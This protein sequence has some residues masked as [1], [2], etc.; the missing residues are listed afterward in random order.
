MTVR[1]SEGG[2]DQGHVFGVLARH[3]V[4]FEI[5]YGGIDEIA[6]RTFGTLT[7]ALSGRRRRSTTP[8]PTSDRPRPSSR[9]RK[10]AD[11]DS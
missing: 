11:M 6:G 1:V 7:L 3:S 4:A 8:S 9:P 2:V 10:D 5:V